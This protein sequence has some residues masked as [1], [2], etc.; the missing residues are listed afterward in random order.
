MP[1][2]GPSSMFSTVRSPEISSTDDIVERLQTLRTLAGERFADLD[3]VIAYTDD[4]IHD[5]ARDVERHRDTLGRLAEIGAT[6]IVVG[7]PHGPHPENLDFLR[8]F[9]ETYF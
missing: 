1:L 7:G 4:S 3:I 8:G 9:A 5:L 6:W 2:T